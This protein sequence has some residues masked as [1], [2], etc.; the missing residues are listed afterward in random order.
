MLIYPTDEQLGQLYE[1][2]KAIQKR[3]TEGHESES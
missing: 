2:M 3:G 1:L